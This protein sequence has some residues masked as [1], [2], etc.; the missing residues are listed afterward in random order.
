MKQQ[1]GSIRSFDD[2]D[3]LENTLAMDHFFMSEGDTPLEK[4]RM[5]RGS[6]TMRETITENNK[7]KMRKNTPN[8]KDRGT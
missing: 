8:F 3:N 7:S 2:K 4:Y 5:S 1:K 6:I